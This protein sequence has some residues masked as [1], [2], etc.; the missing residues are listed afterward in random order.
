MRME[1]PFKNQVLENVFTYGS[2][3]QPFRAS[4]M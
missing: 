1:Q 4:K 2:V 3:A